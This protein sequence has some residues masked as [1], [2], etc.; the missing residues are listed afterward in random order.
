MPFTLGIDYGTNSV[1]ALVVD[2]ADGRELGS[3]VAAIPAASR[4]SCSTRATTTSPA[5]IPAIISSG[6]NN[7]CARPCAQAAPAR[8]GFPPSEVIGIG[9]DTTGSS[10]IPVDASNVPLALHAQW[11]DHLAAQ[12][13]LWK[14]HTSHRE[15][16]RITE[17]AAQASPAVHRQVRQHVFLRM[18]L[19][20]DLALPEGR[21]RGVR[22]G[23]QLG[24]TEPTSSRPCSRA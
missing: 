14:D 18:V 21:A 20:Q 2:T 5:S 19:E 7:P 23:L 22:R 8:R 15:A 3:A 11:K 4:A 1:R 17:L 16:A 6:W 24:G 9:V 13:W 10:P 12:C